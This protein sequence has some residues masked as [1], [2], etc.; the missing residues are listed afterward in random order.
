[1]VGFCFSNFDMF[2]LLSLETRF[3]LRSVPVHSI[4]SVQRDVGDLSGA[5]GA[6]QPGHSTESIFH[7]RSVHSVSPFCLLTL[8]AVSH[9]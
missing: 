7:P 8:W 3:H 5:P 1:M 9:S 6:R 2:S 4:C